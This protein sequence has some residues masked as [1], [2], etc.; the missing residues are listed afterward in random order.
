M[1]NL[2]QEEKSWRIK[3]KTNKREPTIQTQIMKI[4]AKTD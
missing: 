4:Q 2:I 3:I 1:P